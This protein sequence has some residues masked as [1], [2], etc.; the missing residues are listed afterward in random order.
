MNFGKRNGKYNARKSRCMQ[1]HVHDSVFES[2]RCNEL[3][4]L[5]K[6]GVIKNLQIQVKYELIPKQN[7]GGLMKNERAADYVADFVY[8]DAASG[9]TVIEDAKGMQ[10]KDYILKRKW[11]KLMYCGADKKTVFF[12]SFE[13]GGG[14][15]LPEK[16]TSQP[17]S[18][19]KTRKAS[20][21]SQKSH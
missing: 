13:S 7:F 19:K 9:Y 5:E 10:P 12:E 17:A 14:F 1:G 4:V 6:S 11:M 16:F 21:K 20:K 8:E 15:Q 2:S 3:H 18:Q